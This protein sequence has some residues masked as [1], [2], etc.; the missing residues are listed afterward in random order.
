MVKALMLSMT[1]ITPTACSEH[2]LLTAARAGDDR[3][4]EELYSR[5]RGRIGGFIRSR[6]GDHGRAEDIGQE[7]FM[8]ALRR[9]RASDGSIQFKPWIYE[10]AK[11]ACIDEYRRTQRA[12]EVSLD[13]DE[14][15]GCPRPLLSLAPTPPA[16][17]E[18]RQRLDHLR[19][20]FGGLSDSHHQ[21]LVL[22][23]LEGL[24]YEEIGARTGM[25]R[26]MVESALFRARRKLTE[27]YNE[28]ASGRRCQQVQGAI[29]DGRAITRRSFGV[30][31]R[32]QFARHLAHCQPCRIQANLAGVDESL[33]KPRGVGA[34]IAALLPFPLWR[35]PWGGGRVAREAVVRTGSHPAA[36]NSLSN[37]AALGEPAGASAL[38]GAAVAA[39]VLALTGAGAG[40]AP[41]A[42]GHHRGVRPHQAAAALP[43][44]TTIP[45][46]PSRPTTSAP[47][48]PPAIGVKAVRTGRRR[49]HIAPALRPVAR[50]TT[51]A[52]RASAPQ[53]GAATTTA[54]AAAAPRGPTAAG[55]LPSVSAPST[56]AGA[57]GVP[58]PAKPLVNTV[59]GPVGATTNTVNKVLGSTPLGGTTGS[60]G[61]ALGAGSPA[62]GA[63]Q[64]AG[65]QA[66]GAAQAAG[67]TAASI[68]S[69][70]TA[71]ATGAAKLATGG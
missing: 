29:A 51:S 63:A 62:V 9:L 18:T 50:P 7:V 41:A 19:S 17:A 45:Q 57:A 33:V 64:A 37:A 14:D 11:N 13:V 21:L 40:L 59:A 25:S 32:R 42:A 4:F 10:I 55:S 46:P 58:A 34:K 60:A 35:W 44:S 22:R 24:S 43:R 26:Q 53:H 49:G 1:S 3:A 68:S 8:S 36:L 61:P 47:R 70:A 69:V 31:E 52:P 71:A 2:E 48:L 20:A 66:L 54:P 12:R 56:P 38:G 6:V 39:A 15:A 30:R 27:E 23:E 28:L 65:S 5:Y 16:A 67:S